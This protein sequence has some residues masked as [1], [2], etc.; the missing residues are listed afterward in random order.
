[1]AK[2]QVGSIQKTKAGGNVLVANAFELN[3]L[4]KALQSP[5]FEA[6]MNSGDKTAKKYFNLETKAEQLLSLQ[7]AVSA[8]KLS[9]ELGEEIQ[10]RIE[11]V[12]DFVKFNV[13][14]TVK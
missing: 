14:V 9:V 4:K 7:G 6:L 10:A 1:M 5:E 11:K 12:P 2:L 3:N 13:F 8:G